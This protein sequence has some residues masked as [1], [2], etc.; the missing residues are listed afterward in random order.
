MR[1]GTSMPTS[2]S[3]KTG[4]SPTSRRFVE[5]SS[6]WTPSAGP[7]TPSV[8]HC[9]LKAFSLRIPNGPE[10]SIDVD[11]VFGPADSGNLGA[12]LAGLFVELGRA[13]KDHQTGILLTIDELHY[14]D[15]GRSNLSS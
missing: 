5:S 9:V 7:A 1:T 11:A 3:P 2:K 8:G 4:S 10:L 13:A 6:P 12:D 15:G 14:V